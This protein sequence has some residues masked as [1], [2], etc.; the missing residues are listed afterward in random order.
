MIGFA[1]LLL[2]SELA[3]VHHEYARMISDSGKAMLRLLNELL[4]LSK[5]EAG[6]MQLSREAVDYGHLVR[7]IALPESEIIRAYS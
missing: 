4:D 5:I 7:S 1:D 2:E 6:R 3:E